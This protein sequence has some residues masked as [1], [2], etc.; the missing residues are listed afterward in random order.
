VTTA[1]TGDSVAAI[2]LPGDMEDV[3]VPVT[4]LD[5]VVDTVASVDMEG[6]AETDGDND[7]LG[8]SE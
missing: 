8:D 3:S 4:L 6:D 7:T 2:V 1:V 5:T